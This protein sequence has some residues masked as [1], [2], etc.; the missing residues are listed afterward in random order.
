MAALARMRQLEERQV[1]KEIQDMLWYE[2]I[3]DYYFI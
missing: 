2:T 1:E 3:R